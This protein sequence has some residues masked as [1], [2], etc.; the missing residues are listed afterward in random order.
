M[1][2]NRNGAGEKKKSKLFTILI[3]LFGSIIILCIA[4]SYYE[5]N[6]VLPYSIIK[7]YRVLDR[8]GI[9][10]LLTG[11]TPVDVKAAD[12]VILK[13]FIGEPID[14]HKSCLGTIIFV[15]GIASSS[16]SQIKLSSSFQKKGF[17]V[18]LTD[19]R[20]HGLSGGQ[21]TTFGFY[22]AGDIKRLVDTL[23]G[24]GVDC[25]SIYIV[26]HSLGAVVSMQAL[27]HDQRIKKG[28]IM[29]A[30]SDLHETIYEYGKRMFHIGFR[31]PSEYAL[32]KAAGI[33]RFPENALDPKDAAKLITQPIL[34]VHGEIDDR[35]PLY[36][37]VTNFKN[38]ASSQAEFMVIKNASHNDIISK[39]GDELLAKMLALFTSNK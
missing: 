15:H 35:I 19:L 32:T 24:K 28:V 8:Q 36:H 38:L 7:P 5:L 22:E 2:L 39:G 27:A 12:G 29:S 21:Y 20:A 18:V 11:Y 16:A 13:G 25:N 10:T 33:A 17:R 9:T 26:G 34:M 23:I 14:K 4:G 30:F 3:W 37:G 6:Y 31:Y 1:Q